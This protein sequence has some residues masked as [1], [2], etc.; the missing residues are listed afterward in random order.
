MKPDARQFL[1]VALIGVLVGCVTAKPTV[2]MLE[3]PA[4]AVDMSWS[5]AGAARILR[6]SQSGYAKP[7]RLLID[8]DAA[9]ASAWT[10]LNS[11]MTMSPPPI[12][13]AVD[14]ARYSVIIAAQ[15]SH[16]TG[17][18]GIEVTRLAAS[19]DFLYVE[20]T[21]TSPGP[22]CFTTQSFTE[23]VDVIRIPKPHPPLMFVEHSVVSQ[24]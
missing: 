6:Q 21:S 11:G 8:D 23:P 13:P 19:G 18:F 9:W 22:R 17:G 2:P 4:G 24:C 7:V 14:F 1:S 12:R 16:G 15:G 10:T 3:I 20:V 5:D